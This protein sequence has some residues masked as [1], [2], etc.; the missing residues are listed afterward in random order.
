MHTTRN[1]STNKERS[2]ARYNP[3]DQWDEH[4]E[5]GQIRPFTYGR[6]NSV[7]QNANVNTNAN[8]ERREGTERKFL[9]YIDAHR[10]ECE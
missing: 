9:W 6:V 7:T 4:L 1:V 2:D 10:T 3:R 8:E 5:C